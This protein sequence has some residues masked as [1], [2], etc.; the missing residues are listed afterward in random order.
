MS[1]RYVVYGAQANGDG[2]IDCG[3][4]TYPTIRDVGNSVWDEMIENCGGEVQ[5]WMPTG[6]EILEKLERGQA[7]VIK[8]S[9]SGSN[10]DYVW[11]MT[12]M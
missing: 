2:D 7:V 4:S 8:A 9:Q 11:R 3:I 12:T 5:D 6:D 10:Y 1:K